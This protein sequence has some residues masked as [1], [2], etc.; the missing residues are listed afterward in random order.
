MQHLVCAIFI[1]QTRSR[2]CLKNHFRNLQAPLCGIF[3]PR[4]D[5]ISHKLGLAAQEK[6][7][8]DTF[9]SS[10]FRIRRSTEGS[11]ESGS[12]CCHCFRSHSHHCFRS[13]PEGS[14]SR[15]CSYSFRF[16]PEIKQ[17]VSI[18]SIVASAVT[19]IVTST[20]PFA[21]AVC[22]SDITH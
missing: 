13:K 18:A 21:S 15:E 10:R 9:R 5:K 7:F 4:S 8:S 3:Y 22:S 20:V 12:S 17:S 2:A 1:F 14:R 19:S 16:R 6:P 11:A